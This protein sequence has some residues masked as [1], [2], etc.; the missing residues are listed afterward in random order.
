[1]VSVRIKAWV[2]E[3][4]DA[5]AR[6]LT[7]E[8]NPL[9]S[10]WL[11]WKYPVIITPLDSFVY[12]RVEDVSPGVYPVYLG[13]SITELETEVHWKFLV[14]VK[15]AAGKVLL[16][17]YVD[18]YAAPDN[19][20]HVGNINVQAPEEYV[21]LTVDVAAGG[22][23]KVYLPD[24]T[25]TVS[26]PG[27]KSYSVAKGSYIQLEAIPDS[28]YYFNGWY[29][30]AGNK[31]SGASKVSFTA[32]KDE[33]WYAAFSTST[34]PPPDNYVLTYYVGPHGKLYINDTPYSNANGQITFP[35][36]TIVTLR[37]EPDE[38]YTI[39]RFIVD[40]TAVL[41]NVKT[42]TMD[43]DYTVDVSFTEIKPGGDIWKNMRETI[44]QMMNMMMQMTMYMV[45]M[46]M[47]IGMMNMMTG[48]M[49]GITI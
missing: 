22:S 31:V 32:D 3:V 7:I 40:G 38:G 34:Q 30:S 25:E 10:D 42:I 19:I 8:L 49:G 2:I 28:G 43:R 9:P 33:Y 36:G 41:T 14:L 29:D 6:Y 17:K 47:M 27:Q 26:G 39:E 21:T 1:M 44:Q 5:G 23:V 18:V 13:V 24:K 4:F 46:Q 16:E 35:S 20:V 45:M 48:A 15:D 37:A 11:Q 12:D